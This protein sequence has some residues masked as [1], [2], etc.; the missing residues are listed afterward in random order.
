MRLEWLESLE[1]IQRLI[2]SG[3]LKRT[4]RYFGNAFERA[5]SD[6]RMFWSSARGLSAAIDLI[7]A[8]GVKPWKANDRV[9]L[10]VCLAARERGL[11][12]GLSS[13][14]VVPP[15]V[16]EN[17]EIDFL[18]ANLKEAINTVMKIKSI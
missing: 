14:L 10:E 5:I 16:I 8:N 1:K 9:G 7:R 4:I 17:E 18:F 12:C 6:S 15:L 2:E 3:R 13:I 11:C